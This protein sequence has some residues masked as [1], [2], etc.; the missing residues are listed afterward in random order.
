[1]ERAGGREWSGYVQAGFKILKILIHG[2]ETIW[3]Q[4]REDVGS[5]GVLLLN[6]K[7]N[8]AKLYG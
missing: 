6:I 3:Q 7:G 2:M 8:A 5:G 4:T 1:M